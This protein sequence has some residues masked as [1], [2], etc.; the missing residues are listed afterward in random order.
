MH[1]GE[2]ASGVTGTLLEL[3]L[4]EYSILARMGQILARRVVKLF[5][6]R[7]FYIFPL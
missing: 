6:A 7:P 4:V 2:G 5:S 3:E 1:R